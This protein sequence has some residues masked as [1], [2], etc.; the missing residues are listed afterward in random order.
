MSHPEHRAYLET[1]EVPATNTQVIDQA[2]FPDPLGPV[3][4]SDAAALRAE[5]NPDYR[6][7]HRSRFVSW[8]LRAR[9]PEAQA[10]AAHLVALVETT[11]GP[12]RQR[13]K[14]VSGVEAFVGSL[15]LGANT[16]HWSAQPTGN[17]ALGKV[18]MGAHRFDKIRR[19]LATEGLI[20]ALPGFYDQAWGGGECTKFRATPKLL[21][22]AADHGA[23][24][25][26]AWRHFGWDS[27][28]APD[29]PR[30][31]LVILRSLNRSELPLPNTTEASRLIE[32]VSA[33]NSFS[34][35][36]RVTYGPED[37]LRDITPQ[38]QR[39]FTEDLALHGRWYAV[40]GGYQGLPVKLKN[41]AVSDHSKAYRRGSLRIDGEPCVELDVRAS[42]LTIIHGLAGVP[43]L[44]GGDPYAVVAGVPR[45]V[46]KAWVASRI[47]Q[48]KAPSRWSPEAAADLRDQGIDLTRYSVVDVRKGMVDAMPF[49]GR[50][51]P[52]LLG[53]PDRP[54]LSSHVLMGIEG[55]ALTRAMMA[56][57]GEGIPALPLHDALIVRERDAVRSKE[58]L[59]AGYVGE[60][61]IVPVVREKRSVEGVH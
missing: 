48:G 24:W 5:A 21:R 50:G 41:P 22:F 47:G 31:E 30:H 8:R 51:L 32:E 13:E 28:G 44:S 18:P 49:L 2:S 59:I 3:S 61:G 23:S 20:E 38:F 27:E 29:V 54:Q 15:M 37:D 19:A 58:A 11:T 6:P 43:L 10:L 57:M 52:R 25:H 33:F 9:T 7:P 53:V 56:L 34:R 39:I 42:H 1:N 4:F 46:G 14:L 60:A 26:D 45:E 17:E 55:R 35:G 40:G 12:G 16:G 36:F